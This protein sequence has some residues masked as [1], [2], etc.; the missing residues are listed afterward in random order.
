VHAT[1]F[2]P[3]G[4]D[5]MLARGTTEDDLQLDLVGRNV[6]ARGSEC[7]RSVT[8]RASAKRDCVNGGG[9]KARRRKGRERS[10][11]ASKS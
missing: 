4:R 2:R 5:A 7:P 6:R 10:V 9:K 11:A 1:R 8:E 3:K